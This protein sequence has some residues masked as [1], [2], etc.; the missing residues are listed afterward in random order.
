[1][2]SYLSPVWKAALDIRSGSMLGFVLDVLELE[3]ETGARLVIDVDLLSAMLA[4][5]ESDAGK[6]ILDKFGIVF[7]LAVEETHKE[8]TASSSKL[9]YVVSTRVVS[10]LA[11]HPRAS[12]RYM[13]YIEAK[14]PLALRKGPHNKTVRTYIHQIRCGLDEVC[15]RCCTGQIVV[16][17]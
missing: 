4:V 12:H 7:K 8:A 11:G 14:G 6:G 3:N 17:Y 16:R 15:S 13:I 9:D 10:M 5:R 2:K 1:M